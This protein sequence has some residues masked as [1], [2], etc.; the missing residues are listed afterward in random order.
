VSV[1]LYF[2]NVYQPAEVYATYVEYRVAD[3]TLNEFNYVPI[4]AA[5]P[6]IPPQGDY[7]GFPFFGP[8]DDEPSDQIPFPTPV[9]PST[10][11]NP[12]L[13]PNRD[14]PRAEVSEPGYALIVAIVATAI[15]CRFRWNRNA[16]F[17]RL[18]ASASGAPT[19]ALSR[20]Q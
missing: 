16:V 5:R 1:L 15:C 14:I 19:R 3:T 17:A 20:E 7:T 10:I 13:L 4:Y 8:E 11:P 9:I 6:Y 18:V 12:E 2:G